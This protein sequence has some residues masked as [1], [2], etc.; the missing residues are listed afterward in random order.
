MRLVS[1]RSFIRRMLRSIGHIL[2]TLLKLFMG[3]HE[4]FPGLQA[5][6]VW[7]FAFLVLSI[8]TMIGGL[9]YMEF[10]MTDEERAK[11]DFDRVVEDCRFLVGE[12]IVD[13]HEVC[14][15]TTYKG[16]SAYNAAL[17]E[18]REGQ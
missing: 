17:Q 2:L 3:F 12:D 5:L 11:R 10:T 7:L 14:T 16:T 1:Y 18:E 15:K 9:T 4:E 13:F 8:P 6:K